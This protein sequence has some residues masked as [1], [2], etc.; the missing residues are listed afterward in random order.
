MCML[1]RLFS[2]T[3]KCFQHVLVFNCSSLEVTHTHTH[4]HTC[5]AVANE[6]NEVNRVC[7]EKR[8][9]R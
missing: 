6:L 5:A 8:V 4:T 3:L 9:L 7:P 2:L 1:T